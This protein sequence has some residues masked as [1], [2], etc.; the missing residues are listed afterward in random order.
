MHVF[1]CLYSFQNFIAMCN[2]V[3]GI[4]RPITAE[5]GSRASIQEYFLAMVQAL[6]LDSRL[7]SLLTFDFGYQ[8][9]KALYGDKKAGPIAVK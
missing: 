6:K 5:M 8:V 3:S 7:T 1:L 9:K 4:G 2:S